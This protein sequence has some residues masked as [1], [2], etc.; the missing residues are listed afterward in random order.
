MT[1]PDSH[2]NS[3]MMPLCHAALPSIDFF[4]FFF[5]DTEGNQINPAAAAAAGTR[6]MATDHQG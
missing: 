1:M 5:W 4:P 3:G 2:F 6:A